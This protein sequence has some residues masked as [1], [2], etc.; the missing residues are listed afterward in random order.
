MIVAGG[1][2]CVL[3]ALVGPQELPPAPATPREEP[4]G[5]E[6]FRI[7]HRVHTGLVY[8]VEELRRKHLRY[9]MGNVA[10]ADGKAAEVPAEVERV[11]REAWTDT[12]RETAGGRPTKLERHYHAR[13]AYERHHTTTQDVQVRRPLHGHTLELRETSTGVRVK[14]I[15][16]SS[17]LKPE[18]T[19]ELRLLPT[20][21]AFLPE[22]PVA[23]GQRWRLNSRAVGRLL[24]NTGDGP[25]TQISGAFASLHSVQVETLKPGIRHRIAVLKVEFVLATRLRADLVLESKLRGTVRVDLT[26]ERLMRADLTGT[27]TAKSDPDRIPA[28][29]VSVEVSGDVAVRVLVRP[30]RVDPGRARPRGSGR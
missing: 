6:K 13:T 10:G 25:G 20:V 15:N 26:A 30:G 12:I 7:V 14:S 9:V 27:L 24:G 4:P 17:D 19:A 16:G 11:S 8:S 22:K 3:A 2:A 28:G 1:I 23:V 18:D 5:V 21:V 29:A